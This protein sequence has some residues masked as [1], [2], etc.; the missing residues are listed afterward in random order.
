MQRVMRCLAF[1]LLGAAFA[2]CGDAAKKKAVSCG[3]AGTKT[4]DG[5]L[6]VICGRDGTWDLEQNCTETST[7]CQPHDGSAFCVTPTCTEGAVQ[8][9]DRVLE[10]CANNAWVTDTDCEADEQF[11]KQ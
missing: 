9:N 7:I 5:D 4:C 10:V 6:I 3:D 2:A 1:V 8:C 11:C